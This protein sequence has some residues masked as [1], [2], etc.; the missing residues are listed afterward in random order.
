MEPAK[1]LA[2]HLEKWMAWIPAVGTYRD[3]E[4]RRETDKRIR[5][6]IAE[7]LQNVRGHLRRVMLAFSRNGKADLLVDLDHLS[8]QIQQISDTIRYASYGY[9]GI[10][11]VDKI[12]EE[13]I[14]RLCSFDL[15]LKEEA[16]NLQG[17]AQEITPAQSAV[18]LRK[19]I[20]EASAVVI[21]L[22]EKYR[23]R[24]DFMGRKA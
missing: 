4:R 18:D 14:Q 7:Q 17:K 19:K 2:D 3:R 1:G 20:H 21:G 8:A 5:E 23:I 24:K 13:E 16:E 12:R 6:H 10:F 11:E 15:S 9:S 22:Q